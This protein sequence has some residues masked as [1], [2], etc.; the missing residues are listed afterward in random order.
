M[1]DENKKNDEKKD[2]KKPEFKL[3][4]EPIER[5]H[6]IEIDG[7]ELQY[8][9][10]TG[11]LPLKNEKDEHKAN[12]FFMAYILKNAD[13]GKPRPLTFVFNGGPGSASIWLHMGALGPYR[14]RV[15]DEGWMPAPPYRLEENHYT[16]LDQSDLVFI[17]P[18][19]TG[20]S[21]AS[22]EESSK[23]YWNVKGDA[24]S[25]AA[26][27]RLFL[28]R[29]QR[30]S[31]PLFLAGE[32]Y[33]TTRSAA[34]SHELLKHG[35]G[36]T[37][38]MLIST[39][40]NFQTI[41]FSRGNDLPYALY[42]PTYAATARYHEMLDDDL[43]N[44]TMMD[45]M[46]EVQTWAMGE[47]TVALAKG[48]LISDEERAAVIESLARY[49]GLK[50]TYIDDTKL[51]IHIWRFCKELL[52]DENRTVGRLDSRFRGYAESKIAE[53]PEFDPS[54]AAINPPYTAMFNTYI[55]GELGYESD[56]EY[57]TLNSEVNQSWEWER[58][59]FPDTSDD[60]RIAM[61]RNPYMK[62]WVGQ[63]FYDLATPHLGALYTMN[64][65]GINPD[66]H[67]NMEYHFYEA[68]HM[69]YLDTTALAQMKADMTPFIQ[70]AISQADK[71][72][73]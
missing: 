42:I 57:H 17:D 44:M 47:Y 2:E 68:G 29:Y 16:L 34:L 14:V 62:I 21:R 51:R 18:V 22:D 65:M 66:Q 3:P 23:K 45:F 73:A 54:M 11:M 64:H 43:Q 5:S 6:N 69:F 41:I 48:D 39:V 35:I 30:W 32:S 13:P 24:E 52:R 4:E 36:L 50:A 60:L 19:G 31:S 67:A 37:G 70:G 8:R 40:L 58:G 71:D 7:Q 53:F 25:L 46:A 49:T 33:G 63:G 27:I 61:E 10:Y 1:T 38:I 9:T 59:R 28:S 72:P 12:I 26:F 20:Y 55:R 15:Q 56:E